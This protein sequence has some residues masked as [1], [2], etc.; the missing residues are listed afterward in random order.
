LLV[1]LQDIWDGDENVYYKVSK[2]L[3]TKTSREICE[4][5]TQ[6]IEIL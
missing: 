1:G 2:Q 3:A 6:E 4:N 5:D